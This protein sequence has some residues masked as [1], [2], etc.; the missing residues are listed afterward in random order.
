MN[1]AEAC[2]PADCIARAESQVVIWE[3][4][5]LGSK[6]GTFSWSQSRSINCLTT[7]RYSSMKVCSW[8]N[9]PILVNFRV[10]L[11]DLIFI[12]IHNILIDLAMFD[13]KY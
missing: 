3:V 12:I 4:I 11:V 10:V 9:L 1:M 2:F 6:T 8:F 7:L 5:G 13:Y